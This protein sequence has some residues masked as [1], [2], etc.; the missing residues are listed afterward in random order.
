MKK[1]SKKRGQKS[2]MAYNNVQ[3]KKTLLLLFIIVLGAVPYKES[4]S[5]SLSHKKDDDDDD[6]G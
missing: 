6:D 4:L 5:L 3:T 1:K 2:T